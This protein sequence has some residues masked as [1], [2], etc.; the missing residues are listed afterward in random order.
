MRNSDQGSSCV[1]PWRRLRRRVRGGGHR[2]CTACSPGR[3]TRHGPAPSGKVRTTTVLVGESA[4]AP[5]RW[6]YA[7]CFPSGEILAQTAF[8]PGSPANVKGKRLGPDAGRRAAVFIQEMPRGRVHRRSTVGDDVTL[9]AIQVGDV[10]LVSVRGHEMHQKRAAVPRRQELGV[11]VETPRVIRKV[12]GPPPDSKA[13]RPADLADILCSMLNGE[14]GRNRTFNLVIKS[15]HQPSFLSIWH[16][17][18]LGPA[19]LITH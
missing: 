5:C 14:R 16:R 8:S 4:L 3:E 7:M 17:N 13:R 1:R 15:D 6:M 10:N 11:H 9:G 18:D 2:G 12:G 19:T